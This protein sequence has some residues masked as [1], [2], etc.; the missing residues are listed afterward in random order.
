MEDVFGLRAWMGA[1]I[2][3]LLEKLQSFWQQQ[4]STYR[5]KVAEEML[6]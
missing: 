5:E 4:K 1:L 3:W 6:L 2:W